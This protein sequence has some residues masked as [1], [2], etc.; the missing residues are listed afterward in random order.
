MPD[1]RTSDG[2]RLHYEVDGPPSAPP[3]VLLHGLGSDGGAD[4][5]LVDAIGDRLRVV[6]LDLRGHGRSEPL[7]D[8]GRYGWF[9]RA[10][11]DVRELLD[12]LGLATAALQGGS[13]G[14]AVAIAT[15][16]AHPDRVRTLGLS[17]PAIGAGD[18]LVL[19]GRGRTG[20]RRT[21]RPARPRPGP[22][23]MGRA[24]A[25]GGCEQGLGRTSGPCP[26]VLPVRHRPLR[27]MRG[28]VRG[29]GRRSQGAP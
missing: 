12:E 25:G 8:P 20:R 29:S 27:Y 17:S 3:V 5:S 1:L 28:P 6:R 11:A 18:A 24:A 21:I 10:A 4:Q 26:A 2:V 9:G 15:V 16:L 14:A 23:P 13:L 19:R 22:E 7:T